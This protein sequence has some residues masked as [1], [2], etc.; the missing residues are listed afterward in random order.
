MRSSHTSLRVAGIN[1][2]TALGLIAAIGTFAVAPRFAHAQDS[3]PAPASPTTAPAAAPASP[4]DG[5][6]ATPAKKPTQA[7]SDDPN[8]T[9]S[10]AG[11]AGGTETTKPTSD[12]SE[13]QPENKPGTNDAATAKA[14]VESAEP[15][16]DAEGAAAATPE[17]KEAAHAIYVSGDF[18]FTRADVG[19]LSDS[20]GF[21]KTGA[22]GLAY[23][24]AVGYRANHF[25]VGAR[26]HAND[27]TEF[28]L[29]SVM[30]EVGYGFGFRPISPTIHLHGGYVFDTRIDRPVV[31]RSLPQGNLLTP[32]VDIRGARVG[33][34]VVGNVW[35]SETVR[36]GPFLGFD[37][38]FLHRPKV[39]LPQS[40][41]PTDDATRANPLFSG[42][43][44]G[45]GY[46][47]NVGIR[48]T[49]DIGF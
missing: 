42:S 47:F 10:S 44:S 4:T 29:W 9:P 28:N 27:T 14:Q 13:K 23:G 35:L 20:T 1:A 17:K 16:G 18:A 49:F 24:F 7:P 48:G 37:L 33:V 32:D 36:V 8:A 43:G 21:D 34:E 22:N 11:T 25:R 31:A 15:A 19:G 2:R 41:Y 3:A 39:D 30:A 46:I 38:L 40:I 45:T 26:F 5:T 12:A 6:P